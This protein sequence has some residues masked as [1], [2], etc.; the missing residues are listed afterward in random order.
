MPHLAEDAAALDHHLFFQLEGRNAEGQQAADLRMTIVHHR[1]D[2]VA[3]QHVGAGQ[4]GRAGADDR[5]ALAGRLY[6]RHIRLPAHFDGLIADI[7]LD[8]ADGHRTEL[9]VQGAGTLA[10]AILRADA[11]AH[12]RQA[13]G[14][15][16]QIRRLHDA[17]FVRQLQPV[18]DV[19]VNRAFPFAIRVAAG[20]TAVCLRFRLGFRKRLVNL[21]KLNF[22]DLQRF[23]WRINTLQVDKLI[24]ILTH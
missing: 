5:H 10:Q 17:A 22:T 11:A 14:L 18:R 15:V 20:Q 4:P 13:V 23:L 9:I 1:L 8:V 16:R 3:G 6:V 12:F 2:A 21:Y 19:V 7:T 24:N